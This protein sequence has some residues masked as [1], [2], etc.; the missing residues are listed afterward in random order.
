MGERFLDKVI[1]INIRVASVDLI[2]VAS[3]VAVELN[4]AHRPWCYPRYADTLLT[5]ECLP[6][7]IRWFRVWPPVI[8]FSDV[9][10]MFHNH[11]VRLGYSKF[12]RSHSGTE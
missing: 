11:G 6:L 3:D 1:I 7:R 9:K 8:D 10:N 2:L 5:D 4:L 12:I